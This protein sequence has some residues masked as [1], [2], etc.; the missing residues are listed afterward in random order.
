VTEPPETGQ[1]Y[2][3]RQV[4]TEIA[5]VTAWWRSFEE[6]RDTLDG[7]PLPPH[8]PWC[9]GCGP[10]NP[11]GHQLQ[12]RRRGD[13][14]AAE[15]VFDSRHRGAPGIAHGGAVGTVLDDMVGMLLYVI[16]DLA[17][18]RKLDIEFLAPVRLQVPYEVSAM[19][20]ARNGRKLHVAAEVRAQ[21]TGDVVASATGV[22]I[23]VDLAH[24]IAALRPDPV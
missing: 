16:G 1:E 15:H 19:L 11:H 14:V 24:F 17:V 4:E 22:F 7:D 18:T 12:A 5:L 3:E 10:D 13:G 2:S 21:R 6:R 8:H 20:K 23:V 9:L